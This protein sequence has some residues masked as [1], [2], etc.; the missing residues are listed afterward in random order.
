MQ[1]YPASDL[2]CLQTQHL[3]SELFFAC[4]ENGIVASVERKKVS[5]MIFYNTDTRFAYA[6]VG[7]GKSG[8]K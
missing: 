3:P 2:F 5:A 4:P 7:S 8:G 1:S 6:L